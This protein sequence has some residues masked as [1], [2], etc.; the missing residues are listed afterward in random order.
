MTELFEE[1]VT[2]SNKCSKCGC[3]DTYMRYDMISD[4]LRVTCK[5]CEYVWRK[6]PLDKELSVDEV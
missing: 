5:R 3:I 6:E 1:K 2:A 4:N